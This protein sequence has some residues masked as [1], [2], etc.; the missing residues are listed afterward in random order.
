MSG[1]GSNTSTKSQQ[2]SHSTNSETAANGMEAK[3]QK[4]QAFETDLRQVG[5]KSKLEQFRAEKDGPIS[6][7]LV[8]S[9]GKF[10]TG[11]SRIRPMRCNTVMIRKLM[12]TIESSRKV[13]MEWY[14]LFQ[15]VE[16]V[17][18]SWDTSHKLIRDDVA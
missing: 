2:G 18:A 11:V 17:E 4:S 8:L 12:G 10:K 15:A 1:K 6:G 3:T 7:H 9:T 5:K 16:G 13:G 14:R